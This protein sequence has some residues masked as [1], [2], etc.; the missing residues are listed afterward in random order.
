MAKST[1]Q[2]VAQSHDDLKSLL[3]DSA[4]K[5]PTKYL[6]AQRSDVAAISSGDGGAWWG[7]V[8]QVTEVGYDNRNIREIDRRNCVDV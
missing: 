6:H 7:S 3:Q 4:S 1:C 8:S 2:R 5:T